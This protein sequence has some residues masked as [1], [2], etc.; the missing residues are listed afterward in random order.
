MKYNNR[1]EDISINEKKPSEIDRENN[2][3]DALRKSA[4]V[5][6]TNQEF[7]TSRNSQGIKKEYSSEIIYDEER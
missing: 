4:R 7:Y 2:F 1:E 5:F 3:R 6:C